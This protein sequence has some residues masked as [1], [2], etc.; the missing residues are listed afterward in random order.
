MLALSERNIPRH[1]KGSCTSLLDHRHR[2]RFNIRHMIRD[3][4]NGMTQKLVDSIHRQ[5][6]STIPCGLERRWVMAITLR[7]NGYNQGLSEHS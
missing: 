7:S 5:S 6:F 2:C 3:L 1:K 4:H